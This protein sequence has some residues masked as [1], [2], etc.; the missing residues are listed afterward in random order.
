[1]TTLAGGTP[2]TA[3]PP[4]SG[5]SRPWHQRPVLAGLALLGVYVALSFLNDPRGTLGTD[6]GIKVA[7][8]KVMEERGSWVPDIGYWAAEID[9]DAEAHPF[10]DTRRAGDLYIDVT[11]L[12]LLYLAY[13]LWAVGGYR[14]ALLWPMAGAVAA[15]FVARGL[16]R[17]VGGVADGWP[18]FWLAGLASPLAVYAIDLWEHSLGVAAMGG[19]VLLLY[20]FVRPEAGYRGWWRGAL[21]GVLSGIAFTMRTEALVY[22]VTSFGVATAVLVRRR[23]WI[24]AGLAGGAGIAGFGVVA[25]ANAGLEQAAVGG[26]IRSARAS[27]TAAAVGSDALDRLREGLVTLT[28]P[29]ATFDRTYLLLGLLGAAAL[30]AAAVWAGPGGDRRRAGI[31]ATTAGIV[32]VIRMRSGA[33]FWPGMLAASPMA[34]VGLGRGW[35]DRPRRRLLAFALVPVPLV[36]AFQFTGGALPQWGGRYLLTS[37]FVLAAVGAASLPEMVRWARRGAVALSLTVTALG[38]AWMVVRTH[39]VAAALG[40]LGDRPEEVLI[41]SDGFVPREFAAIYGEDRWLAGAAPDKLDAA[42]DVARRAAPATIGVVTPGA[43]GDRPLAPTIPGY[44]VTSTSQIPF[45]DPIYL[46]ITSYEADGR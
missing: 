20:D 14:A 16:A 4:V 1:M 45:L 27:G 22:T 24:A 8:L 21:A 9:G 23:Q 33:G 29:F 25:L 28:S 43:S 15:A 41:W 39:Q 11:T 5:R 7:T 6:T 30:V 18:A 34:A 10:R 19:T 2:G 31:A 13:P 35:G 46:T 42:I 3:R 37:G 17:R 36:L 40:P 38:L 44:H 26:S 12:P 32:V